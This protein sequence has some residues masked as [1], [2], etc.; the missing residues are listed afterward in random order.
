MGNRQY[1]IMMGF[2]MC[3]GHIVLLRYWN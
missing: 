1:Y 2:I 3:T